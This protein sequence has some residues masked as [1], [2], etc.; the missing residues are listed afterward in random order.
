MQVKYVHDA[1][2]GD[3]AVEGK[4]FRLF[5]TDS[6]EF[7]GEATGSK[8]GCISFSPGATETKL[9]VQILPDNK[10]EGN[11][12]FHLK[13]LKVRQG[14]RHENFRLASLKVTIID[15]TQCKETV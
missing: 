8:S 13:I 12:T 9:S 10:P 3:T 6:C 15:A 4:D 11:E 7:E 1:N 14:R 2:E 5:K